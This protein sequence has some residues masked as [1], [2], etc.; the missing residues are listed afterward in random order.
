[1]GVDDRQLGARGFFFSSVSEALGTRR[2]PASRLIFH[3]CCLLT[4]TLF[5]SVSTFAQPAEHDWVIVP[6]ARVGAIT[7]DTSE[8][9]LELLF[10][11]ENLQRMDVSLGEGFF[12]P[13]TVVYPDDP[14]RRLE[15]IWRDA[16]R[17]TPE[18]IRLTGASSVWQTAEGISL[19]STLHDIE[20]LNGG[21]FRL[22]GFAFDNAGTITDCERGHL[23]MLGCSR[24]D[25]RVLGPADRLLVIRLKPDAGAAG[26]PEYLQ[27]QGDQIFSSGHPA[28]QALN[29]KV[30]QIIVLLGF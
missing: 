6:G 1:M 5:S 24:S 7:A 18:S 16:L 25:D 9:S 29:P 8:V 12:V 20:Q 22:A 3:L 23:A 21:P 14:S 11:I 13:G 28:M 26:S 19:G 10:G 27:V 15:V 2:R 4:I 30:Y 17:T